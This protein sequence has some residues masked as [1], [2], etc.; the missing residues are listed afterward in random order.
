M[1]IIIDYEFLS[2]KEFVESLPL[3]FHTLPEAKTIHEGRNEVKMVERDGVKMVVKSFVRMTSTNRMIY[4]SLRQSKSMRAY[5]HAERL[6]ALGI[7]TPKPIAAIDV[8]R[9]GLLKQSF[10]VAEY[11]D[12]ES[13]TILNSHPT[14]IELRPLMDALAEFIF[15]V[16]N[17]GVLHQDLNVSN[18]LYKLDDDG[19]YKFQLIDNNRIVFKSH[20]TINERIENMR[21]LSCHPAAYAYILDKYAEFTTKDAQTFQLRGLIARLLFEIRQRTKRFLKKSL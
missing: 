8:Q 15:I 14:N 17:A 4:G 20:L 18:I 2:L 10:F 9:Y 1:Q 21:R 16:H 19:V 13:A 5:R 6:L 3:D 7:D 11:S 12:Y